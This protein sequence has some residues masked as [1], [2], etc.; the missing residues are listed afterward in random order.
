MTHTEADM[1]PGSLADGSRTSACSWRSGW[2]SSTA[3]RDQIG[4]DAADT[5]PC[6]GRGSP[7]RCRGVARRRRAGGHRSRRRPRLSLRNPERIAP[8]RARGGG[9]CRWHGPYL[10][11]VAGRPGGRDES[12]GRWA[13]D[14][15]VVLTAG[16]ESREH[17]RGGARCREKC[18]AHTA[19]ARH[20][21]LRHRRSA[22]RRD[23]GCDGGR[24]CCSAPRPGARCA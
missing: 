23:P 19:R 13:A 12:A 24:S 18:A 6:T 1:R 7:G 10:R 14:A 21:R 17:D 15:V 2:P 8:A 3:C 5:R 20:P 22:E 4:T 9:C 16:S 11:R